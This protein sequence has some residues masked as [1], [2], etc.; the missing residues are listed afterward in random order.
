MGTLGGKG[1]MKWKFKNRIN[2]ISSTDGSLKTNCIWI[3]ELTVFANLFSAE[4]NISSEHFQHWRL[5]DYFSIK[6]K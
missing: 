5:L 1:L 2:K 6:F 3:V 4:R